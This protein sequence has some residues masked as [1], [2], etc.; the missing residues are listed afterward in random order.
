[1]RQTLLPSV[2]CCQRNLEMSPFVQFRNVPFPSVPLPN[3][4]A[5]CEEPTPVPTLAPLL[6]LGGTS[7]PCE[8]H[9]ARRRAASSAMLIWKRTTSFGSA[10]RPLR[11][12]IRR[13]SRVAFSTA[14]PRARSPSRKAAV[15]KRWETR[16]R[17]EPPARWAPGP[18]MPR[19]PRAVWRGRRPATRRPVVTPPNHFARAYRVRLASAPTATVTVTIASADIGVVKVDDAD[20]IANG[21]QSTL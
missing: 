15:A 21:V 11:E 12:R 19:P 4:H 1:M 17:F 18:L 6:V 14:F 20:S 9:E 3:Y 2:A 7:S 13:T 5:S 10:L 8:P 16:R